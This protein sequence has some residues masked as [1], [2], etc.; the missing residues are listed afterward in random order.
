MVVQIDALRLAPA[1]EGW[2]GNPL[3]HDAG[4]VVLVLHRA[5]QLPAGMLSHR[6]IELDFPIGNAR[7]QRAA[8]AFEQFDQAE[9][10]HA[11]QRA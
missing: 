10:S 8:R 4:D 5:R 6:Q 11:F 9:A 7:P 1:A 2:E 3:A